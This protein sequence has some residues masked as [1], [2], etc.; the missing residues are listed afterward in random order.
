M[1]QKVQKSVFI[2]TSPK[3]KILIFDINLLRRKRTGKV[4]LKVKVHVNLLKYCFEPNLRIWTTYNGI[5]HTPVI[6]Q[7]FHIHSLVKLNFSQLLTP[8]RALN[9]LIN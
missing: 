4:H 6:M 3:L 2:V 5:A 9:L 8:Q 7:H 1:H